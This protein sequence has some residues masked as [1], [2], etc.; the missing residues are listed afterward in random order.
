MYFE[1]ES[2]IYYPKKGESVEIFSKYPNDVIGDYDYKS[3]MYGPKLLAKMK[4]DEEKLNSSGSLDPETSDDGKNLTKSQKKNLKITPNFF[5]EAK[6]YTA[7]VLIFVTFYENSEEMKNKDDLD[8]Q[9]S[10]YVCE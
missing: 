5:K 9:M 1:E 7:D 2:P 8:T 6:T 10:A 3:Q 4:K